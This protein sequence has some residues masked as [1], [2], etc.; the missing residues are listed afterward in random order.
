MMKAL[1][2]IGMLLLAVF[3]GIYVGFWLMFIGGFVDI[4]Q[5]IKAP[6]TEVSV[7]GFGVLK[8]IFSAVIGWG[9]VIIGSAGAA[10]VASMSP[11]QG[12]RAKRR[13]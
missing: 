6:V 9:I 7:V 11:R 4:I 12:R 3:G 2:V 5:A 13:S 8:I 1:I 10:L